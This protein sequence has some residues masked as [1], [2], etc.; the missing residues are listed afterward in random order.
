VINNIHRDKTEYPTGR[1]EEQSVKIELAR[2]YWDVANAIVAFAVV[3]MVAF[4]YGL[5]QMPFRQEVVKRL[6]LVIVSTAVS[7]LLYAA[8]VWLCYL[9]ERRLLA[10]D[11]PED[12][13]QLLRYTSLA[14]IA[15]IT[16]YCLF[17][18]GILVFG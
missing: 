3:Q 15:I 14:R 12:V 1:P 2:K 5:A 11:A 18:I 9:A 7:G 17:G 10:S 4:L 13:R 6:P 8:G 16:L